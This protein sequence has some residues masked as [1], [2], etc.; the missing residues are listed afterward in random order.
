MLPTPVSYMIWPSVVLADTKTVMTVT[1]AERAYIIPDGKLFSVKVISVGSDE[2]YYSPQNHKSFEVCANA[3][4]LS[5]EYEFIGE[6]EH[7]IQLIYDEKVISSFTVYSLFSDLYSLRPLK[8]D[9]HSHSCRSDGTRDPAA[10]AGHYREEGYDFVALTDHNRYFSG[11]EIDETYAG[12]NTGLVRVLGEEVHSPDS[13]VHIV[14]VGGGASVADCYVHDRENYEADIKEYMGKVPT[15]IPEQYRSRYAKAMWATDKIHAQGGIA[16]F[17]HPFWR[18]GKSK[19][20]NVTEEF[21]RILLKSGMFDAYEIAG[22]MTQ[23]DV[24]RSVALW[25]SV[26]AE[27]CGLS[28]VGSSDAHSLEKSNHFPWY[29]TVC[30]A[31]EKTNDSIIDAVKRGMCVAVESGGYEYDRQYR[32]YGDFR[33]VSYAQFLLSHYF[34]NLQR[35]AAGI[36]VAMRAYA[37]EEIDGSVIDA[38]STIAASFTERFFGRMSPRLPSDKLIKF[39]E[40]WR[41][42]QMQGP[43]TRGSAVDGEPAKS[44]I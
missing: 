8:G 12:V 13:V 3:G 10:Q 27:G 36:G 34:P 20:Y 1:A 33:L 17:P 39:E 4:F 7:L 28:V 43:K 35:A 30:F 41:A 19:T 38:Y 21:A 6:G 24:N 44:L 14:H 9:L 31:K 11:G 2:N 5:F 18:P 23:P 29:F 40:K 26:R 37:M 22:A 25:S 32:C 16:I 15:D 42:V